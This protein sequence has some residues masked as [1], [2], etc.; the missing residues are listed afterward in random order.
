MELAGDGAPSA[1]ACAQALLL[2]GALPTHR[3]QG[4]RTALSRWQATALRQ[5]VQQATQ[6][7]KLGRL[8]PKTLGARLRKIEEQVG[9]AEA[10]VMRGW[11][12]PAS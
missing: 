9:S 2:H 6:E 12:D 4:R 11:R 7:R 10:A 8:G 1:A 3:L 5:A